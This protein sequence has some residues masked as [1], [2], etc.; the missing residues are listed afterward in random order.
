MSLK[1]L[2]VHK[3]V[4]AKH[5]LYDF[6]GLDELAGNLFRVTQ[7]TARINSSGVR[8][9]PALQTTAHQVGKDVRGIMIKNSGTPPE[10]LPTAEDI[11]DVK[12]RLKAAHKEM[13]KMDGKA[14][15]RKALPAKP[16]EPLV[17]PEDLHD[18]LLDYLVN[19]STPDDLLILSSQTIIDG[20]AD[21]EISDIKSGRTELFVRGTAMVEVILNYGSGE[22]HTGI[23]D[24]YPMQFDLVLDEDRSIYSAN[25]IV[26]TSSFYANE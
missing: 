16:V 12:K 2:Q 23:D 22:D 26:D 6:M 4:N 9:L 25:V 3:G 7:T 1:N 11:S 13:K 24:A 19:R 15:S 8:G 10:R 18:G 5:V 20:I 14:K 21:I 17:K